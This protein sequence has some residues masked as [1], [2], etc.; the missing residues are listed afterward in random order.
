MFAKCQIIE[1]NTKSFV[2]NA[3]LI[4]TVEFCSIG[5][6]DICLK[7]KVRSKYNV[8]HLGAGEILQGVECFLYLC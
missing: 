6:Q 7:G 1:K 8:S 5:S 4:A 3:C 2:A